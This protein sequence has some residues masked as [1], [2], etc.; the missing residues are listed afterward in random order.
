M[1]TPITHEMRPSSMAFGYL[2]SFDLWVRS[3]KLCAPEAGKE[4]VRVY[5]DEGVTTRI[6]PK[7]C[8]AGRRARVKRGRRI[9]EDQLAPPARSRLA[10]SMRRPHG[11]RNHRSSWRRP[12][13]SLP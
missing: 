1:S 9:A 10:K 8:I 2:A 6:S 11:P 12:I 13:N 5:C 4:V 7:L 3:S